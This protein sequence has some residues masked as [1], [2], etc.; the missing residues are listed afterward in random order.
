MS[1]TRQAIRQ[2]GREEI[3]RQVK[4]A[5]PGMPRQGRRAIERQAQRNAWKRRNV[6]AIEK[7]KKDSQIAEQR[8]KHP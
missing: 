3:R 7:L 2:I 1:L 5:V 8:V 4:N 6:A